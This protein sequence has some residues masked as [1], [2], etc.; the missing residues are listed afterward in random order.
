MLLP[1]DPTAPTFSTITTTNGI[2]AF[3]LVLAGNLTVQGSA[4]I[5]GSL[6]A[7]GAP[8]P[9]VNQDNQWSASQ[10]FKGADPWR[11]ITAYMPAGGCDQS[12]F[13]GVHTTGSIASGTNALTIAG[14]NNFKNGCGIFIAGAGA[15]STLATLKCRDRRPMRM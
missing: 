1:S 14:D 15:A 8:V 3:S 11:D 5:T 13:N 7:G 2:S 4:A 10:R 6:S 9:S 12:A